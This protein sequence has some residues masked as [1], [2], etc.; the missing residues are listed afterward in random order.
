[1]YN[2]IS[3][4]KSLCTSTLAPSAVCVQ[5]PI[6]LLCLDALISR[7]V[8]QLFIILIT[9]EVS[10]INC[11]SSKIW[12]HHLSL[13]PHQV[14]AHRDLEGASVG[15]MRNNI[16]EVVSIRLK[17]NREKLGL[18]GQAG[19]VNNPILSVDRYSRYSY[20]LRVGRS[21]DRIPVS[22]DFPHP[23]RPFLGPSQLHKK[24]GVP[25]LFPRAEVV[26]VWQ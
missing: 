8:V 26:R 21:G 16:S 5:C 24:K 10:L 23:S 17:K 4:D 9:L 18:V 20:S 6:W 15:L 25:A 11:M 14:R 12:S 7:Y 1:M 3:H 22:R 2:V 13:I 19:K